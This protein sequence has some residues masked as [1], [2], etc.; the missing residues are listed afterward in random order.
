MNK[1]ILAATM[2]VLLSGCASSGVKV[3]PDKL[4]QFTPGKTTYADVVEQFGKPTTRVITGTGETI[5]VYAYL[6]AQARPETFIPIVGA[7]AGGA[8][9]ESTS[10]SLTFDRHGILERTAGQSTGQGTGTGFEAM[11]QDRKSVREVE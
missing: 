11:S 7:F 8:D 3:D 5:L 6:S 4:S 2:A 10:V 9:V 1:T